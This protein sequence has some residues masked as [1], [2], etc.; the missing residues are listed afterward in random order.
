LGQAAVEQTVQIPSRRLLRGCVSSL[1]CGAGCLAL[2]GA[3]LAQTET[4]AS[5]P[6]ELEL[7]RLEHDPGVSYPRVLL[8]GGFREPAVVNLVLELASDGSVRQAYVE[9]PVRPELDAAALAAARELR[10]RPARRGGVPVAAKI[11][12]RYSFEPPLEAAPVMPIE[13]GPTPP[14]TASAPAKAPETTITV[15]GEQLPPAARSLSRLEVRQMPGAFGDPFRAIEALP[16]VTPIASGLPFFYV[17]GAPPGNVGYFL[18]GMR[19]PLLYHVAIGP[20]VIHPGLIARVDLHAGGYPARFG[21]YA[22][23]IVSAELEPPRPELHGEA[24]LRLFDA[25]ALAEGGFG[26]GRGTALLAGRYSY[27]ALLFSLLVPDLKLDYRDYQARITY[28]VAPDDRVTLLSL[29]SYDLLGQEQ[30]G[31]VNVLFGT[32]FYRAAL[33]HDHRFDHGSLRTDLTLGLDQSSM[34]DEGRSRSRSV[35]LRTAITHAWSDAVLFRAGGDANLDAYSSQVPRYADPDDPEVRNFINDN[36]DRRDRSFGVW[37]DV[38]LE[39]TPNIRVTPGLRADL[40]Q[41]SGTEAVALEPRISARFQVNQRLS[42]THAYGLVHQPPAFVVPLPGRAAAELASGLQQAF[43]TSSGAELRLD[44]GTRASLNLFYNAFF[45]VTDGLSSPGQGPPDS[46][47]E[48]RG[49]GSA[50][51]LELYLHRSLTQRVGGFVSY[52]LS[53]SMRSRGRERFPDAFDR[54]HVLNAALAYDLGRKWRAGGRVVFY[55]GS[56]KLPE[57]AGLVPSARASDPPRSAPFFRLDLRLE[58]RWRLGE[59]TWM[60]F[61]A[62]VMNTTLS[63]E[64]FGDQEIGPITIPS[65]GLEAGF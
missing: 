18:D 55:T 49:Q 2:P 33:R 31:G 50:L 10:F 17:R 27:S 39:P 16:G 37:S 30:A 48:Q 40:Y 5:A 13:A 20:A 9:S 47:A 42:M 41:Q 36:P 3:T 35:G 60:S 6:P 8:D 11:R 12:F 58:K 19:V 51:G 23:G 62:E 29:G 46:G 54:T 38:V 26:D 15:M 22:G 57:E 24:N 52:T 61:V 7:P 32:E 45:A 56:P 25:G 64:N 44:R 59:K 1:M 21:R 63:R 53:R 65:L 43:Q 14:L 34:G 4:P 28:D